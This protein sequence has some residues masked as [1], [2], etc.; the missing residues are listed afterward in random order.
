MKTLPIILLSFI[1]CLNARSQQ[2]MRFGFR[3]DANDFRLGKRQLYLVGDTGLVKRDF[4]GTLIGI[5]TR[6]DRDSLFVNFWPSLGLSNTT[7]VV[8]SYGTQHDSDYVI[9]IRNWNPE[10]RKYN[11]IDLKFRYK[12]FTA[13]N[14]PFRVKFRG[15]TSLE[16]E[17]LNFNVT[18]LTVWGKTRIYESRFVKERSRSWARGIYIGLSTIKNPDTD[19]NEFGL[20]YGYNVIHTVNGFNFT[21]AVGAENGF[22]NATKKLNPYIAFGLGFKLVEAFE[23][24]IKTD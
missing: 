13:T 2:T 15:S 18:W 19:K 6:R 22:K 20:N 16:S 14:I 17:F 23:P 11:S 8:Q 1:F 10:N 9:V 21:L 7:L 12:Q 4:R 24:E 3:F 5:I